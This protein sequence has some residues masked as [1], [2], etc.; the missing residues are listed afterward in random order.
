MKQV[1]VIAGALAFLASG[2]ALAKSDKGHG[3]GHGNHS[4]Q[5]QG[6][7]HN[8]HSKAKMYGY[9]ARGC[10]PGLAKH[11][12]YC[13]PRGQFKKLYASG[14]RYPTNYGNVWSYNQIP[15]D[16]RGQYG[17]NQNSRYYYGDGYLYQVDPRTNLI[18]Q[19]VNAIMH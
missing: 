9:G 14:Q 4:A 18:Q 2:P 10:P 5:H 17:F 3:K 19:V 15:Q 7:H 13:M 8:K 16:L 6:K 11:E 1:F 12:G